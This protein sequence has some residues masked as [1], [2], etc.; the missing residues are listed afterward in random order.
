MNKISKIFVWIIILLIISGTLISVSSQIFK[1]KYANTVIYN[2][3]LKINDT[4]II[5]Q[6]GEKVILKG[7]SSNGIQWDTSDCVNNNTLKYLNRNWNINVF[8]IAVYT[9]EQGYISNKEGI[10]NKVEELINK[11][12]NANIYAIVDWHINNDGNPNK[13]KNEA[14]EF[15][16]RLSKKYSK[17]PNL[18]YEICNEPNDVS[19]ELEIVPYANDVITTIRKNSP[20]SLII[21]GTPNFSREIT[22]VANRKLEF[23]NIL[24]SY[25]FYAG[26]HK[27]VDST[28]IEY[29]SSQKLPIIVSECGTSEY[30]G[31]GKNDY[32]ESEK[33]LNKLKE[34][35][36]SWIAWSYSYQNESSAILTQ[37]IKNNLDDIEN[38]LTENGKYIKKKLID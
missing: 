13:Y 27:I 28:Q 33:W 20:K 18:I 17:C 16:D 23:N 36:I 19:W 11:C 35:E 4:S 8:R 3:W 38:C 15:F 14:M 34:Y 10:Y 26:T 5:N 29:A 37:N 6:F 30:T 25:H 31:D 22:V 1:K 2:G 12:I 32:A 7:L 24:Y 9:E 21:V